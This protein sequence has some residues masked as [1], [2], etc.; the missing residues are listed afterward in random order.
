[1]IYIYI[2]NDDATNEEEVNIYMSIHTQYKKNIHDDDC[3][4][5]VYMHR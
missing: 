2:Q 1:M 4:F 5:Y 3:Y